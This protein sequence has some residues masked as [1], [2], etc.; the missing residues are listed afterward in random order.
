MVI[1]D[2][3]QVVCGQFICTLVEHLI[4]EHRRV[5]HYLA[6]DDVV[7]V[8]LYTG[9]DEEA[10]YILVTRGEQRIYLLL[11]E[12]ER[13]AHLHTGGGVVLEI[14]NL[15]TFGLQLLG[16]IKRHVGLAILE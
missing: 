6:T 7:N 2:V 5:D 13:V 15:S 10:H 16:S 8:Y 4:V 12:R 14:S 3:G 11:G 1:H 9:L